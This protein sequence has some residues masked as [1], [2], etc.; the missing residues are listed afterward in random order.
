MKHFNNYADQRF[1]GQCVYCG[2]KPETREHVPPKVFLDKPYPE[3][4]YRV[5]ACASC[6]QG[7][8]KD[9]EYMACLIDCV[10][11]GTA[12]PNSVQRESIG[13]TLKHSKLL[14]EKI[15]MAK[16]LIDGRVVFDVEHERI[17]NVVRKIAIGHIFYELN[18]IVP[19]EGAVITVVPVENMTEE[20]VSRFETLGSGEIAPWPEVGSRAMQRLLEHDENYKNGWLTVQSGRYRYAVTQ[21]EAIEIRIVFSEYLACQVIWEDAI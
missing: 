1:N 14:S 7:F 9:E 3:N 13:N 5:E 6:N 15:K 21:S 2:S 10:V 11:S 20:E 16:K 19:E 18:L 17:W 8:S 4:L 12:D